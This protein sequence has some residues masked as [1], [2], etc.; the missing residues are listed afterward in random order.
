MSLLSNVIDALK[1][2]LKVLYLLSKY[3]GIIAF[4]KYWFKTK[5]DSSLLFGQ[6]NIWLGFF[7]P[8]ILHYRFCPLCKYSCILIRYV[9]FKLLGVQTE[10]CRSTRPLEAGPHPLGQ[11]LNLWYL[12]MQIQAH[13]LTSLLIIKILLISKYTMVHMLFKLITEQVL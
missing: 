2:R 9:S 6:T 3:R 11:R 5:T 7:T 1:T 4:E 12:K 10:A 13:T 8:L